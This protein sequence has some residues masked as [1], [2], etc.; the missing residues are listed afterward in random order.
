MNE[1]TQQQ[2]RT[3]QLGSRNEITQL[4]KMYNRL[5]RLYSR[6]GFFYLLP[7]LAW[8]AYLKMSQQTLELFTSIAMHLFIKK[9][10]DDVE[11]VE[12]ED[13]VPGNG[14]LEDMGV[15]HCKGGQIMFDRFGSVWEAVDIVEGLAA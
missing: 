5:Q 4:G 8:Q 15:K 9:D 3:T 2:E 10:E 1:T 13:E 6:I 14:F 7:S 11:K 12:T